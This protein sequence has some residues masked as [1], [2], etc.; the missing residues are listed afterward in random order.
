MR[1]NK[2][3]ILG[4]HRSVRRLL[5][6]AA[7]SLGLLLSHVGNIASAAAPTEYQLKAA[8]L[9]N[10]AKFVEWPPAAFRTGQSPITI[11]VFGE[12]R[13]GRDLDEIVKGQTIGGRSVAVRRITQAPRADVCQLLF[14]GSTERNQVQQL[15]Q[16]VATQPILT[17]SEEESLRSDGIIHLLLEDN[18]VRFTVNLESAE[19][20]GIKISSKLLKLAKRVY[21]K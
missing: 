9:F 6:A 11:C 14:V 1:T 4:R 3:Y 13:F 7:V 16:A 18:R 17:V 19:R 8:F 10:F 21:E 15:F 20:A 12:D 5:S 2:S